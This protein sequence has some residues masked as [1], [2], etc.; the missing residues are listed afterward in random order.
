MPRGYIPCFKYN[1][2]KKFFE[3][4]ILFNYFKGKVEN[5]KIIRQC[6]SLLNTLKYTMDS[7]PKSKYVLKVDI[8]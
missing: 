2:D 3:D 8:P 1:K 4:C 6:E 7:E 5:V